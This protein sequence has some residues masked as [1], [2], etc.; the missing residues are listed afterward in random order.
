[1][2]EASRIPII[3]DYSTYEKLNIKVRNKYQKFKNSNSLIRN[4]SWNLEISKTG[5]IRPSG[6]CLV[7]LANIKNKPF[8]IILLDAQ[9]NKKRM[10]DAENIRSWVL[11]KSSLRNRFSKNKINENLQKKH[12]KRWLTPLEY[13]KIFSSNLN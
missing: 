1:M 2:D 5:F 3:R 10:Q 11:E 6:N 13:S 7:M 8:I 4:E 9:G 12:N